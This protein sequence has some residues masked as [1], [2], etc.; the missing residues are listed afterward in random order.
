MMGVYEFVSLL[1]QSDAE[2]KNQ[3]SLILIRHQQHPGLE[4]AP[5]YIDRKAEEPFLYLRESDQKI[6]L[7]IPSTHRG[8]HLM[9]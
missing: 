4:E 2:V 1:L 3:V 7:P 6:A 5:S 9:L 8:E